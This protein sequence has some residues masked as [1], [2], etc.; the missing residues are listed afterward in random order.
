M[1]LFKRQENIDLIARILISAIFV[2]AIPI[3]ITKFSNVVEYISSQGFPE[4]V[5]SILL[6][7]SILI[8]TAGSTLLIITRYQRIG[9]KLLLI[10]IIPATI[11]FHLFP[12][13][14][15][16]LLSNLGLMGA[17]LLVINRDN[18]NN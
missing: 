10:F 12:L 2:N 15:K 4:P 18:L 11:I 13:D 16:L 14:P 9:A 5:S 17:L 6:V 3:K 7:L 8:L 1:K